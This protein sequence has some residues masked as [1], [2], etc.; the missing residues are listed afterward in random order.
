MNKPITILRREFAQNIVNVC[1]G[2]NLPA[3]AKIDVL[4]NAI[5]TL[6][7]LNKQELLND[8]QKYNEFLKEQERNVKTDGKQENQ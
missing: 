1:N 4:K 2:S 5:E 6:N 7:E 3:F 8:I